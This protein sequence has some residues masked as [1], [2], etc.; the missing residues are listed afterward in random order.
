MHLKVVEMR[1]ILMLMHYKEM[2]IR[3]N[4]QWMSPLDMVLKDYSYLCLH[5][6][7]VID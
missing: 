4:M 7:E 3:L 2:K 6:Q 1:S 5:R